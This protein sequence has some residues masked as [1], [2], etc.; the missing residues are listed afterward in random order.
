MFSSL[1]VRNFR[2]YWFGM[3]VSLIGTWIQAVAQS[4]L[5]FELTKSAFLLGVVGFLTY[6]P[7]SFLSL[8]GGVLADRVD[9]RNI[10]IFTQFSFMILAFILALLTQLKLVT[11]AQIMVIAVLNGVV[12]AFDAPSRQAVVVEMVGKAHLLNAIALN[13]A[14]FNSARII[15]PALAGIFISTVGMSGCFYINGVSFLAAIAALFLI[16]IKNNA[17]PGR[18]SR[19]LQ[20]LKEGLKFIKNH[21][22]ILLLMA[23]VGVVSL[24]GASYIILMP[25]F[26]SQVLKVG[27]RGLGVL[28]SSAGAGALCGALLLARLGDFKHK[29]RFLIA[30][31]LVFSVS[32]VLFS[33]SKN[34]LLALF[35]LVFVGASGVAAMALINTMLQVNVSDEM[36]GRVMS[37]FMFTFAGIMPFGNLI[38]GGITQILGASF[39]IC[40]SGIICTLFFIGVNFFSADLLRDS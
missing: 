16:K 36:R 15:G 23:M 14:A 37:V 17:R 7:I 40:I 32:L 13:S 26:A 4:W 38:A 6:I 12:M 21:R 25:V 39:A 10:L 29:G 3:L 34:Y 33:L 5:V 20:D 1:K 28:M 9:K 18:N 22:L 35:F 30:S 8:F 31:S 24:F 2:V 27:V 19:A 11:P